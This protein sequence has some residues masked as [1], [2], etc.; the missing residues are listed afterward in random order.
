MDGT[1]CH[2]GT[3]S[4][5]SLVSKRCTTS[6]LFASLQEPQD[7]CKKK[8]VQVFYC[9]TFIH[10]MF[11]I[12]TRTLAKY[13]VWTQAFTTG[14][15][16]GDHAKT[17]VSSMARLLLTPL[18]SLKK[19]KKK[20]Y[21]PKYRRSVWNRRYHCTVPDRRQAQQ[22]QGRGCAQHWIMG[23][24]QDRAYG[25]LWCRVCRTCAASLVQVPGPQDPAL[26]SVPIL[27]GTGCSGPALLCTVFYCLVL[28]WTRAPRRRKQADYPGA[29]GKG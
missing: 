19:K 20:R 18:S 1:A 15:K 8:H 11:G 4:C 13:P 27:A 22:R 21:A 16:K 25:N 7:E 2:R 14:K 29:F 10:I 28:C 5:T 17:L 24:G 6:V 23:R 12:Y 9:Q 26:D 3:V